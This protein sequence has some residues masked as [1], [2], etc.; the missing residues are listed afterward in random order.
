MYTNNEYMMVA[1]SSDK[2][3]EG[4]VY[5]KRG[6]QSTVSKAAAAA[7]SAAESALQQKML[8]VRRK[9]HIYWRESPTRLQVRKVTGV[10]QIVL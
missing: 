3:D 2:S 8:A 9:Y 7:K 4:A 1:V 10:G 5:R 6:T